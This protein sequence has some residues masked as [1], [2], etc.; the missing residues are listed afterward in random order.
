M[1]D[2]HPIDD[3]VPAE[4]RI[5]GWIETV[6]D[7]GIRRPC[8]PAD[9]WCEGW[10]LDRF[11]E[12]GLE[13][14]RAEPVEISVWE[15]RASS[16]RAWPTDRPED[17][18]ELPAFALPHTRP[19]DG[20]EAPLA[21][22]DEG[23]TL[24]GRI[25][26]EELALSRVPQSLL[27]PG[28]TAVH[29]PDGDFETL[30]QTLPFGGRVTGLL[31]PVVSTGAAGYI[32][33][34]S[35]MPWD[36]HDYY[37]PY[38]GVDRPVPG[39]W[40]SPRDGRRLLDLLEAGPTTA[41]IVVDAERRP[42]TSHNILGVLPGATEEVVVIGSHHDAP[43]AS[44]VEDGSGIALVLAQAEYWSSVPREQ[45]PHTLVFVLHAG[46]MCDGAGLHAMMRDNRELLDRAVLAVHLEH[47]AAECDAD[48][49]QLVPTGH[50]EVRWWFT[51]EEDQLERAVIDAL[52]TEDL[53]RSMVLRPDIF[54]E[55]PPTD[56]GHFHLLG[57][58]LV[59]FLAAPMYLFDSAD[60]LD[61]V[62]RPSLVP[63]TRAAIRII[64][65]T[66][67]RSAAAVRAAVR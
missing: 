32:G 2:R 9:E 25:A 49:D 45:R 67:G 28:A 36:T 63:L 61:K 31:D 20:T 8:H 51:T 39:V 65:S 14:V 27:A 12:L 47:A 10:L 1:S 48:G 21:P 57:V 29:D 7:A 53:R 26:V 58:P 3:L 56:G 44:A 6:V 22:F 13:D 42:G 18:L 38:D 64:A 40:L 41:R 66:S 35:G 43:W 62:H 30:V 50:P 33:V 4:D 23:A 24:D 52:Q 55:T 34:L 5:F 16:V 11:R 19:T 46:H 54:F 37:V 15:H 59:N 60:T 17:A